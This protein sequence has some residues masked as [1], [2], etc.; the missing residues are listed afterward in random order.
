[1]APHDRA[2]VAAAA[3][4]NATLWEQEMAAIWRALCHAEVSD[5]AGVNPWRAEL[6]WCL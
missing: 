2:E 5:G 3:G 1:V 4:I 6:L